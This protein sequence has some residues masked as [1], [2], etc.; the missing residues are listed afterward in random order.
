MSLS[1]EGE[2]CPVCHGYLFDDDDVVFC[3]D[4][5]APH[6]RSCYESLGHCALEEYHGT[7]L[8][9]KRP[10]KIE[11]EEIK[12]S[13][14]DSPL[15]F[16]ENVN[17]HFIPM[18]ALYGGHNKND[19][20]DGVK[21]K[22]MG[23]VIGINSPRYVPKFFKLNKDKKIS[24]NWAA[25][26]LP[27]YWFILRKNYKVGILAFVIS[28]CAQ[29]LMSMPYL[30]VFGM[31]STS[32]TLQNAYSIMLQ[33]PDEYYP[34]AAAVAVGFVISLVSR[35]IFGLFGDWIYKK[36][37]VSIIKKAPEPDE[38][39]SLYYAQKGGYNF[40]AAGIAVIL[41]NILINLVFLMV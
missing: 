6:H 9:Y 39:R 16:D 21:A 28:V 1:V 26:L 38:E 31:E 30:I 41:R 32:N 4:C 3:V 10:E 40:L 8:E 23:A 14:D 11:V 36:Q 12:N 35:I 18:S 34:I 25:F 22:D 27:E 20:V 2:K 15:N 24:W 19:E 5:G 29:I 17:F 13:S 33:N 37:V 7:D